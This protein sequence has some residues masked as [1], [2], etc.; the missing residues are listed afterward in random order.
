M[1]D[2]AGILAARTRL[3]VPLHLLDETGSTND[4]AKSG[5]RDGA[6]H[7]ALWVAETQSQGRGRQGR[8]WTSPRGE[9]LLFSVLLRIP[10][11]PMRVPPLALVVGLAVR[12]AVAKILGDGVALKW[13]NDVVVRHGDGLRKIAGV[14]VESSVIGSRVDHLV[15]GVGV[16]VRT[17]TF[18]VEL[19]QRATSIA[20]E[21]E[22]AVSPAQLLADILVGIENDVERVAHHGLASVHARLVAADVLRGRAVNIDERGTGGGAPSPSSRRREMNDVAGT[23]AGID[24]DGRLLVVRAD[25]TVAKVASG[26]IAIRA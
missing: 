15:V 10:C 7:G 8:G 24:V 12:D 20:I 26:E 9:N 5:A 16:N 23:G 6:P 21:C 13:P 19:R 3:G 18:P 2:L 17:R 11:L 4:D 1:K 25:G 14:L 22:H